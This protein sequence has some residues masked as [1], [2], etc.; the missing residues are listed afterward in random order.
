MEQKNGENFHQD[1]SLIEKKFD[2]KCNVTK[3]CSQHIKRS[4]ERHRGSFLTELT[5]GKNTL[6]YLA[7]SDD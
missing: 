5:K 6:G 4:K 2:G 1:L 7:K 3:G